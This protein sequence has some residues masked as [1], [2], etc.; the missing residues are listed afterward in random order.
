M[1]VCSPILYLLITTDVGCKLS[2][3]A[4]QLPL[5]IVGWEG[6]YAHKQEGQE[7]DGNRASLVSFEETPIPK[8]S[9][10]NV[11]LQ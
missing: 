10:R 9:A 4:A 8:H 5:G 3:R 7:R 2:V 11:C 1:Q 6:S